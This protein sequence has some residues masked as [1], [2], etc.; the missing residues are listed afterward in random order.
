MEHKLFFSYG[1]TKSGSTLAFQL[2]RTALIRAG[3][4]QP[5]SQVP[6]LV[7][8]K[9]INAIQHVDDA[10][11]TALLAGPTPLALK[12]HTRC[13]PAIAALFDDCT[14]TGHVV[15]RDPRDI[16][17]SMLDNG[18]ANRERGRPAFAEIYDVSDAIAAIEN[19]MGNL[20]SWLSLPGLRVIRYDDLAF[21]TVATTEG[22]LDHLGIDGDALEIAT[23]V[24]EHEFIQF[25]KGR[26]DRWREELAEADAARIRA[27][28]A[29]F[30]DHV[31]A[32]G[33]VPPAGLALVDDTA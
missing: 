31:L 28:F 13:D 25:N 24:L 7:V 33:A 16:A 18:R 20:V 9:R 30:Y 3:Y 29:P 21:D 22:I 5:Q 8:S 23:H 32:T 11:A 2:T 1:L 15:L 27:R 17:L 6:D 19:Q 12:T 26:K 14:A 4:D 10:Q